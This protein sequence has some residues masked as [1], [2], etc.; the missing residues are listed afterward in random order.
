MKA[1]RL[2][3]SDSGVL[4][5]DRILYLLCRLSVYFSTSI[6]LINYRFQIL[7]DPISCQLLMLVTVE[8]TNYQLI[9]A[10]IQIVCYEHTHRH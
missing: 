2:R 7:D 8:D 5:F 10:A 9:L 4:Y 6:D 3:H 1:N